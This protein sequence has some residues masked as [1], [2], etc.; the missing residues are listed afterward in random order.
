MTP[1]NLETNAYAFLSHAG[2]EYFIPQ[3]YG[4]AKR[5]LSGWGILT[6]TSETEYYGILMEW[7][8]GA[9]R[10]NSQNI[11]IDH[12]ITLVRGLSKIH[13]A[14]VLHFDTFE[15]NILVIPGSRRAVW[16]DFSCAQTENIMEFSFPQETYIGGGLP[17][18][19]VLPSLLLPSNI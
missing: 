17:M 19:Y 11:T 2:V 16:I 14:G 15:R 4:V 5:T 3:V 8:D 6:D 18:Y 13:D 7:I 1:Y 9:E 10:L 12:T